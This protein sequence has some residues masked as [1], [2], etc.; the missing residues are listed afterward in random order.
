MD[1]Y[2]QDDRVMGGSSQSY[3]TDET[4]FM[5]YYGNIVSDN[6]GFCSTRTPDFP[7]SLDFFEYDGI[8]LTVRSMDN[9]IYKFGL[10]DDAYGRWGGID[11]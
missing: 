1:W 5:S 2:I 10:Q 6:G 4:D 3:I 9:M 8:V 7:E 11:W